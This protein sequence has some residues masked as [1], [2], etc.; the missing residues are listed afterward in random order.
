VSEDHDQE[1]LYD[2]FD[3]ILEARFRG[4][5]FDPRDL[6]AE[7][8][9]LTEE[10]QAASRLAHEVTAPSTVA[11]APEIAGYRILQEIGHGG[12]GTVY[13]AV[14]EKLG[15]RVAIKVLSPS[16]ALSKRS[17]KR[18]LAEAQAL[19]RLSDD[20]IVEVH[21]I[22]DE[23]GV[24]AYAMEWVE[25]RS[26]RQ[27]LQGLRHRGL[28]PQT[29]GLL[30]LAR[31]LDVDEASLEV[32][33]PLQ[34]WLQTGV[35]IARALQQVHEAGIVHRDVKP[36]N[37]LIR[38][39]GQA[40]LADFGLARS[41]DSSMSMSTGFV[42][43]PIYA[44][45]EQLRAD[46]QDL[47][48]AESESS[49]SQDRRDP[50]GTGVD[51]RSDIYALAVTL[52]EVLTGKPPF[53]GQTTAAVLLRITTGQAERLRAAA[54]GMPRDLEIVLEKAM[55]PD[56]A[57][58]YQSAADLADDIERVLNLEPIHAR[59][60]LWSRRVVRAAI[61]NRRTLV[62]AGIGA[63]LVLVL[64]TAWFIREG[65]ER[66]RPIQVAAL[67][68][69]A[70]LQLLRPQ[71]R[72]A[73]W[74]DLVRKEINP[75]EFDKA[76]QGRRR[77]LDLYDQALALEPG[78]RIAAERAALALV[79]ALPE[80]SKR[81]FGVE[82]ALE[83]YPELGKV[84]SLVLSTLTRRKWI[85][86]VDPTATPRA[87]AVRLAYPALG[88]GMGGGDREILEGRRTWGLL[89]FLGGA[90][91]ICEDAWR[92]LDQRD[93]DLPLMDVALSQIYIADGRPALALQRLQRA[94]TLFP[95]IQ[96]LQL[97]LAELAIDLEDSRTA[98]EVLRRIG[99]D[100]RSTPLWMTLQARAL[101]IKSPA[102]ARPRLQSLHAQAP[103]D[104]M[105]R[106]ALARIALRLGEPGPAQ[107][108]LLSLVKDYPHNPGYRLLLARTA[109]RL[110][111][112]DVYLDQV[113][114]V[115]AARFGQFRSGGEKRDLLDILQLGGLS[116]LYS[117]AVA[118]RF[119]FGSPN[120]I[121]VSDD[122]WVGR[123]R[124]MSRQE[125]EAVF[126]PQGK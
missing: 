97:D 7:Q 103:E 11:L 115:V 46:E 94:L 92:V 34:F 14:Q 55:D 45:P 78:P 22:F 118:L 119:Q 37:I 95:E 30:D 1:S 5:E 89:G 19:A 53:R 71:V 85:Q 24:L 100:L 23:G 56:P 29:M 58:R 21:D 33:T 47:D 114:Y 70:H 105:P 41:G 77:A 9:G 104:P 99:S 113:R 90:D 112:A 16:L 6:L 8:P 39:N 84:H 35:A 31:E 93:W 64:A 74:L 20:H 67:R 82:A 48:W 54:P 79:L 10:I 4:K 72:Q 17:R 96:D 63:A 110:G 91:E 57:L 86:S 83:A 13:L 68:H 124:W 51:H 15:R 109:L 3:E 122:F 28:S 81:S 88:V 117:H 65:R 73:T 26:L 98:F 38:K 40:L 101:A 36:G 69:R 44:S 121:G 32:N 42:G 18:F 102:K 126:L 12:M 59:R 60:L 50:V 108:I 111:H 66:Q 107:K 62:A 87:V 52:Y 123:D 80:L 27:L 116:R 49:E 76:Q 61:R 2:A 43:T 75:E 120:A 125:V 25:G 106:F